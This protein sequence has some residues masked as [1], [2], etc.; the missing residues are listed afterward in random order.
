MRL[1]GLP[2]KQE[3][4]TSPT[5]D[6]TITLAAGASLRVPVT[7]QFL[8]I[9]AATGSFSLI[10]DTVNLSAVGVGDGFE[11]TPYSFLNFTD[12]SGAA[13]T[14]RYVTAD[15]GYLNAPVTN[16]NIT[17][18]KLPQSGSFANTQ[19]TVTNASA[20]LVG[21]NT[22]RQY[23]CIQNKDA[24]GNVWINFG[25]G[26]ATQANGLKIGPGQPFILEGVASTQAIQAIGDL[27]TQS[28]IVVVE[29]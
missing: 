18:T 23:L 11:K 4:M 2:R 20:Q 1:R 12:T 29:G 26:A 27:A 22:G 6:F 9:L 28:N 7:A 24:T 17:A 10:T 3:S 14:I 19:K 25:A 16:T 13:N 8:R 21:A 5:K 15:G